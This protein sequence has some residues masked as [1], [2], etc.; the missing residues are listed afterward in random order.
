MNSED[1]ALGALDP[2]VP[3]AETTHELSRMNWQV[4]VLL[5]S[6]VG[7]FGLYRPRH[8]GRGMQ[9]PSTVMGAQ[10]REKAGCVISPLD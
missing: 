7:V 1:A 6:E 2:T 9:K 5:A 3:E 8:E 10:D 4:A